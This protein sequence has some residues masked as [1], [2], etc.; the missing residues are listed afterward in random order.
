MNKEFV[1]MHIRTST[2]KAYSTARG[3]NNEIKRSGHGRK[4]QWQN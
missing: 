3:V 1:T 4:C 2:G